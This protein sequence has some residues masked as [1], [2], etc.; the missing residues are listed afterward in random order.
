MRLPSKESLELVYGTKND[1]ITRFED[2]GVQF[3]AYFNRE[4]MEYFSS[5]GRTE[6]IGNHTDHNNGKILAASIDMDTIGAASQNNTNVITVISKEYDE[7]IQID[8]QCLDKVKKRQG[9]ESLIAGILKGALH[10]GFEVSGFDAYISTNVISAAGVSS[11]ASFEMLLCVIIDYLFNQSKLSN[12]DYAKIGQYAENTYWNKSSGLMDQMAC[13]VGGTILLDFSNNIK[14]EEVE[15]SFEHMGYDLFIINTGKGHADLSEEYSDIPK[16]MKLVARALGKTNLS[17]CN[18][19]EVLENIERLS[20]EIANDRA[21]L[22]TLHYFE[23]NERVE[24]AMQFIQ[25]KE[26]KSLL[27]IIRESGNSSWKWLQNCYSVSNSKEQK[28]SLTLSLT[29]L[30][31]K[32][33]GD[34][35]CRVHGGGFAGVILTVIPKNE[36]TKYIE[37]ISKF[38]DAKDIFPIH[39]R[40]MGAVH[41]N[42]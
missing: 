10:F 8:L 38:I 30:F 14:Y 9:T 41:L 35:C 23:E 7:K 19:N 34:G 11:S 28:V 42:K 13:A 40:K 27:N 16:E 33:I 36:S 4:D 1:A 18:L 26:A 6:I 25:K 12:K 32:E 3:K 15:V 29:E 39:I 31:L 37:Y 17:E 20:L 22:R 5:P 2:L 21:L 24:K